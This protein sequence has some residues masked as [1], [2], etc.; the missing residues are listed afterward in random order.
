M[1]G[2]ITGTNATKVGDPYRG[3]TITSF[4]IQHHGDHDRLVVYYDSPN[5]AGDG[6]IPNGVSIRLAE[7]SLITFTKDT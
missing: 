2:T 5:E 7:I 3:G 4:E 6:T 1:Y